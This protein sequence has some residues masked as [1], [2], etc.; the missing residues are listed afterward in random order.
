MSGMKAGLEP[1]IMIKAISGSGISR[2]FGVRGL[3]MVA[4]RYD[5]ATVKV[6]CIKRHQHHQ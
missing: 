1:G 6:E 5:E 2:M 3:L 4:A